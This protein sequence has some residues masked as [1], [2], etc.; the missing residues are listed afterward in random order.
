MCSARSAC[1]APYSAESY[2]YGWEIAR[3]GSLRIIWH[4][5]WHGG[6]GLRAYNGIYPDH[7]ATIIILAN[8]DY[9]DPVL[10]VN[11]L[12]HMLFSTT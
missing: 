5:G 2:G 1:S 4:S 10:I 3:E 8:L 6:S 11:N 9:V 12:E 7:K